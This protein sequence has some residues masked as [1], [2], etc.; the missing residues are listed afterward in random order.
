MMKEIEK[1]RLKS[2]ASIKERVKEEGI[3]G[4][5]KI[6]TSV[7]SNSDPDPLVT[8]DDLK[9]INKIQLQKY[10]S[11]YER[12]NFYMEISLKVIVFFFVVTG[13]VLG[14]YLSNSS[15][16][17]IKISLL[18]PMLLGV[19]W[20]SVFLY[21]AYLWLKARCGVLELENE[22]IRKRL[23]IP[24]PDFHLLFWLLVVF[25]VGFFIVAGLMIPVWRL[26]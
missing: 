4:S 21:G 23:I 25:G 22:L 24:P 20:G 1:T 26:M 18:L 13:T 11:H 3:L 10:A 7:A 8:G 9:D 12:Y 16:D 15:K 2:G 14:F 5:Y 6:E 19:V 17:Y